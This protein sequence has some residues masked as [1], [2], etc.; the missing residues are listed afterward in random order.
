MGR[1]IRTEGD[2]MNTEQVTTDVVV[3]GAG[4]AGLSAATALV[5]AGVETLVLEARDRVGGRTCTDRLADGTVVDLGGQWLAPAT[6]PC[7]SWPRAG[8]ETFPTY[9]TG[10]RLDV[11]AGVANRFSGLLPRD[12][13]AMVADL[14][15]AYAK[16][17]ALMA[18]VDLD[19][20]WTSPG[21]ARAGQHDLPHLDRRRTSARSPRR[22]RLGAVTRAVWAAEPADVSLLHILFY[23]RSNGGI[24][25][26]TSTTGGAQ[27]RRFVAGSQSVSLELARR[28]GDR[29]RL[30]A[31]VWTVRTSRDQAVVVADGVEVTRRLAVIA[32]PPTLAGQVRYDPALPPLRSQLTQRTPMGSVIKIFCSYQEP[33][34][35]DANLCGQVLSD[36]G[37]VRVVFDNSPPDGRTG[38]PPRLHRGRRCSSLDGTPG[39][40]AARGGH[41]EPDHL[42]RGRGRR[43]SRVPRADMGEPSPTRRLLRDVPPP[44]VWTSYGMALR[45]PVGRLHWAGSDISVH[46]AGY[47]DGAV[48]SGRATAAE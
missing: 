26:L 33:F 35:R 31:P 46:S 10:E 30:N 17:D 11:R 23:A 27:E 38:S 44:G 29:V 37:P 8:C 45:E 24:S 12:D 36:R 6:S 47:M 28:L 42:L 25:Q 22:E 16:L 32:I 3:V 20:P 34:W 15:N 43:R 41:R 1:E 40:G 2:G 14:S 21:A 48:L 9:D 19:A 4:L 13:A 7:M 39:R 5:E 18:D